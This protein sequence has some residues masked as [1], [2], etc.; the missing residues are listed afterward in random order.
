MT[1]ILVV[2]DSAMD[3]RLAGGLL[4]KNSNWEIVY[5]SDGHEA[6]VALEDHVPDLVVTDL[7]MPNLNGLELVARVKA[8]YPL[9]PVI[10]MTAQGSEE[11][12]VRALRD[13]AASYVAKKRLAKDLAETVG[14]VLTASSRDRSEARLLMRRLERHE[15]VFVLE[16]D[17]ALIAALVHHFQQ[18]LTRMRL[19]P[20]G[21]CLRAAIA[22]DEALLNAYYHGNLEIESSLREENQQEYFRLAAERSQQAPYRE[23]RIRVEAKLSR[24]QTAYVIRDEGGGFD[25]SDLPDPRDPANLDRPCGRGVMLMRTFMDE[26]LYNDAGN[27]VTLIKRNPSQSVLDE[28]SGEA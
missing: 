15:T 11:I 10:V 23:R 6:V 2:D 1:T 24:S 13:G 22:L 26:V 4:E 8:E 28:D 20:E 21:E 19:F 9:I 14:Q 18:E 3:R 5:A 17:L 7:Q 16:N 27:E 25:S 12:A